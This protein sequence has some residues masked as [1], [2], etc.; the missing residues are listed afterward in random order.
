MGSWS[1]WE[2]R[3]EPERFKAGASREI[4]GKVEVKGNSG[5]KRGSDSRTS[6]VFMVV[7]NG[8]H[9]PRLYGWRLC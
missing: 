3:G 4:V 6:I 7:I 5:R 2:G 1:S 9:D 8:N